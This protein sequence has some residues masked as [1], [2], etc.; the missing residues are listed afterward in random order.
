MGKKNALRS[1][2]EI[3]DKIPY[4]RCYEEEGMIEISSHVFTKAYIVEPVK[5]ENI[6]NFEESFLNKYF[7]MLL[8]NIPDDMSCQFVIHNRI[9]KKEDF[10]KNV[11]LIP[12][13]DIPNEITDNYNQEIARNMDIG[14]NNTKKN[15]YFVLSVHADIPDEAVNRFR[16]IDE[17]IRA[18]FHNIYKIN[19]VGQTV[20]GRLKTMYSMFNSGRN[21]FG[22]KA[23]LR[24][25]GEFSIK[26][27]ARMKL[28][29]KDMIA[30]ISIKNYDKTALILNDDTY[31]RTFFISCLPETLSSNFVS[32][33]T[34]VSS[35]MIY[36]MQIDPM[37]AQ[38][39]FDEISS[40]IA[41]NTIVRQHRKLDTVQDRRNK[42]MEREEIMRKQNEEMYFANQALNVFKEAIA[43]NNKVKLCT[44]AIAI[45]ADSIET[46]DRDTKLLKISCSKFAC[47]IKC[48]FGRQLQGLQTILPLC[49]CKIDARRAFP[50]NKLASMQPLSIHDVLKRDGMYNGLNAINDNLVLINRKNS[51]NFA[52]IISGT[53]HSGKTIQHKREI[54]NALLSSDDKIYIVSNNTDYDNFVRSFG[55]QIVNSIDMNAFNMPK[56][57]G[58]INNDQYSKSVMLEA[59]LDCL[60]KHGRIENDLE[61]FEKEEEI[62]R[63]NNRIETEIRNIL[64]AQNCG[65]VDF[66]N[67]NTVVHYVKTNDAEY[68]YLSDAIDTIANSWHGENSIDTLFSNRINLIRY[69]G[70]LGLIL[71]LDT[72]F[73]SSIELRKRN[74]GCWIFVDSIDAM[75]SSDQ[76]SSYLVDVIQ[77]FNMIKIPTTFVIDSTVKLL[78]D[79]NVPLRLTDFVNA[80]GYFKLLNQGVI[81]RK[82][83]V[84]TLNIPSSLESYITTAEPGNGIILTPASNVAFDDNYS[85]QNTEFYQIFCN[86]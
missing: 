67:I 43:S 29:T 62:E 33:I 45:Y 39:G 66:D 3:T 7:T 4:I 63:R 13:D 18:L 75:L 81:E 22:Q 59:V 80:C 34:S 82:F 76:C 68:P 5:P 47:Q 85:G 53:E 84:Q 51:T 64:H 78:S 26:N 10:L 30:P 83:Y 12:K 50:T 71:T 77:K 79:V 55:G 9:V 65:D 70:K 35:N 16:E 25:D 1:P 48:L 60:V 57:Y 42:V 19:A 74:Q 8:N 15:T 69:D 61:F 44:F 31:V 72:L 23:D 41:D 54:L 11:L 58:I 56:H 36:S 40:I 86:N 38:P 49:N 27:M 6:G 37:D 28:S 17:T 46:L 32:D 52:G 2:Q 73:T 14:H 21:T 20:A 24:G